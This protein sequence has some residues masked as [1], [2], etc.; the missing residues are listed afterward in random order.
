MVENDEGSRGGDCP[1]IGMKNTLLFH[2]SPAC[3]RK[4][5]LRTGLCPGKISRCGQW[6]PWYVCLSSSPSLAW[7]LSGDMDERHGE[8]DLWMVW[9]NNVTGIF[10]RENEFRTKDRI[11]KKLIWYVGSRK[12]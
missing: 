12:K 3:R 6:K 9:S 7:A 2:W 4:S 10:R 11:R 5:I 1:P 8:W